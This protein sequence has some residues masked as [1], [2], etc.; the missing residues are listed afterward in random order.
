MPHAIAMDLATVR[1]LPT[2][3]TPALARA[4][5]CRGE[6]RGGGYAKGGSYGSKANTQSKDDDFGDLPF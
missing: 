6:R 4:C 1:Q 3:F 5:A 2:G